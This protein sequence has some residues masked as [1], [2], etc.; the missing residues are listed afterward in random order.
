MGEVGWHTMS[1]GGGNGGMLRK[2]GMQPKVEGEGCPSGWCMEECRGIAAC[3]EGEPKWV[4][5]EGC[6]GADA[7]GLSSGERR[8]LSMGGGSREGGAQVG[9]VRQSC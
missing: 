7:L 1:G 3:V 9:R 8:G 6:A 2:W 5:E 4:E